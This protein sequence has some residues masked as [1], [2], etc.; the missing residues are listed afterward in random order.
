MMEIAQASEKTEFNP[1]KWHPYK[2]ESKAAPPMTR[3]QIRWA[4][5]NMPSWAE[6]KALQMKKRGKR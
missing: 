2:G 5:K 3:K 1:D 6:F 4:A